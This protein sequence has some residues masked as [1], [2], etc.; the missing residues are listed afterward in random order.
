MRAQAVNV[1][2]IITKFKEAGRWTIAYTPPPES[3]RAH[4]RI[5]RAMANPEVLHLI[6]GSGYLFRAYHAL[7]KLTNA[8]GEP[9]GALFGVVN[10]VR[11]LLSERGASKVAFVFDASGGSFRNQMYPEYKANRPPMPD[12]LRMQIEPLLELI[13][14]LG[15]PVLRVPGVEADDVIATLTQQALDTGGAVEISTGD[16]DM[17]QLVNAQVLWV[18]SMSQER[19][20]AD[21]VLRKHGVLPERITD[22]LALMGD[23]VDNIPG[24]EKCGPKTAVKWLSEYGSMEGVIANADKITGKIGEYLRQAIPTL[25]LSKALAT[26]KRDCEL[27]LSQAELLRQPPDTEKLAA[28]YQR[29]GFQS[30]LKEL[31]AGSPTPTTSAAPTA[32]RAVEKRYELV[33]SPEALQRW[34][35]ALASAQA[36]A[37]DTETTGLNPHSAALVG[38]SFAIQPGHAAYV[39]VG[40]RN[41]LGEAPQQLELEM[42][43]QA[44]KP[45]L[46][47]PAVRKIGHHGKYDMH[48]LARYGIEVRGYS[49]DSM[50]ASYVLDASAT[51]HNMDAVAR[52]Y[53][54][55]TTISYEQVAGKGA[56]Q[57]SFADVALQPALDYAAEDADITLQLTQELVLK[58]AE[59]PAQMA[60]YRD[61][62]IP[63]VP[64]L[65]QMEAAGIM[66]DVDALRLQSQQLG[67]QIVAL[68]QQAHALI[69]QTFSIDSPKQLRHILFEVLALPAKKKTPSGEPSTDEEALDELRDLHA[70]PGLIL[71]YRGLSKLKNTYTDKLPELV[72]AHAR[73]HTSFHQAV[74]ATGR[75]SSTDPNLQN[76]P[77]R[78]EVGRRIRHAFIA[79]AGWQLI[80]ADYSQIEL[81]IMAHL[82]DD[83]GLLGAFAQGLDVHRATAA[84]IFGVASDAVD[85]DQRRSA[86]AINFGL[87]YG[88][89]AFRLARDLGIARD[90]ARQYVERYFQRYPGVKRYM[91]D[92]RKRA[93]EQGYVETLFGRRLY[94]PDL[95]SRDYNR[96]EGAVRQAINAP[97]QGTAAD[98]IKRAMLA[99]AREIIGKQH[100]VRMLLQ[101]HDELIFEVRADRAAH[102]V[103]VLKGLM[104]QAATLKVPLVVE[105][106]VGPNWGL[107]H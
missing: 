52:K 44:L 38:I 69:G 12:E 46:E 98:I 2:S 17:C 84:E 92:T 26:V 90:V 10:M 96:R 103:E 66:L 40:H 72:D 51:Q 73:V 82:S 36:F 55:Y 95:N 57:I 63:L 67:A 60:I 100:E 65:A 22:Y 42:V 25:P 64:V 43:L 15:V 23:S 81:R 101:V 11:K 47:N 54:G 76:I 91:D 59:R 19:L 80:S 30:A 87:I 85:S 7:P 97:M 41:S 83:P 8:Q 31:Q 68:E 13:A 102:Y 99:V 77:I 49:D 48:V 18:N 4:A 24:V 62:E 27:P 39:P 86:K 104:S 106:G 79:P 14:A 16:K 70:L 94:L 107:A 56:K 5:E 34:S 88:M 32:A 29:Y 58:L 3:A 9:T 89:S 78:T 71:E 33:Q 53:L 105:A 50:L 93:L 74:A 45:I 35:K 28:L 61:M 21:G 37:F 20:D 75:L 1:H 6:D